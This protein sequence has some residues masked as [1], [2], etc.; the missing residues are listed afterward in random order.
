MDEEGNV[1]RLFESIKEASRQVHVNEKSIRLC[2]NR[3]QKH[4]GGY[5]WKFKEYNE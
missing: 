1:I 3:L 2:A 5:C 4:A